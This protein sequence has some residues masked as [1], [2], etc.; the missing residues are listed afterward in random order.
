MFSAFTLGFQFLLFKSQNSRLIFSIISVE[1]SCCSVVCNMIRKNKL[2]CSVGI[3]C[4]Q[5]FGHIC[6]MLLPLRNVPFQYT[7]VGCEGPAILL[8]HGFGAF[9]EHFRDN[10]QGIGEGGNQ[11]W[12]ITMLGFGRSE[13]PNVVYSELM[14]AEFLRDFIVEVVGRPVHLVGNS[15]G[16]MHQ[17][18]EFICINSQNFFL[19][20]HSKRSL[21]AC[22]S[23]YIV[24]IIA[25]L[26]PSLVKSI[27][28]INSAGSVIPEYSFL[29][30][31]KVSFVN[32]I[33]S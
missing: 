19:I 22:I 11:V 18:T 3:C 17:P 32:I 23:G 10:I 9:L 6:V 8:V 28:L 12:A 13:K 2:F 27:V 33:F 26:W 4:L 21:F 20:K 24:A 14:W 16:G 30:Y 7:V 15:I 31:N 25:R 5:S 1:T 29:P